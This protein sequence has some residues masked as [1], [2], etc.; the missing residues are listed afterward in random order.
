MNASSVDNNR[1]N[2]KIAA[3]LVGLGLILALAAYLRGTNLANNPGWYSDEGTLV[4][5]ARHLAAGH[6]QYQA[7]NQSV[8]IAARPPLFLLLLSGLF[9]FFHP[10]I[11]TLRSFTATLGVLSVFL[12]YLLVRFINGGKRPSLALLSALL[13]SIY[14]QAVLYSRIGFSYNLLAPLALSACLGLW[15]Y[16][17]TRR[18]IWLAIASL[19]IGLGMV[20]D[21]M[22][23]AFVI[24]ALLVISVR[25]WR[26]LLV[27]IVLMAL[28]L[29]VYSLWMSSTVPGAFWFD[30]QFTLTRLRA[31]P[32]MA[33]FPAVLLNYYY[34]LSRDVWFLAGILGMFMASP[35]RWRWMLLAMFLLPLIFLGRS[36]GFASGLEVYYL[37]ALF[38]LVAIGAAVLVW[39]AI[40]YVLRTVQGAL[41]SLLRS[42]GWKETR[43]R[44]WVS[45]LA[46]FVGSLSLFLIV[47]SPLLLSTMLTVS[48]I[49]GSMVTRIDPVLVNA[50]DGRLVIDYINHNVQP[51]D[52]VVASPA[53]AW[54]ILAHSADF[55]QSLAA[56][57]IATRH[58][59][60]DI[61]ADRFAFNPDYQRARYVVI[62]RI[63]RN[64]AALNMPEVAQ[65][66][67]EVERWPMEFSAG[68]IQVYRNP[69]LQ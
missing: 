48:D 51:E 47:I 60:A 63:W 55:Q 29:G 35:I 44:W 12:V 42:W 38:P 33:Q 64:W 53:V 69:K 3:E 68:E 9:Q 56:Q 59:P 19:S 5:I 65:M 14:P 61:P 23:I 17:E 11:T 57:G 18:G 22:M 25:G 8:L 34:L 30:L 36:T 6:W 54:A 26:G 39:N 50:S 10:D 13:L 66:M 32:W 1:R 67:A 2:L 37:I 24:P 40:P 45:R 31:L 28:P 58:F 16:L 27:G 15:G 41:E 46:A 52:L 4:D 7:L 20:S 43:G 49:R 21:L 62:D